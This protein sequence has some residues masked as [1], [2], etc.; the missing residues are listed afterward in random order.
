MELFALIVLVADGCLA[1]PEL[2]G[3]LIALVGGTQREQKSVF[4]QMIKAYISLAISLIGGRISL[5]LPPAN[6]FPV[7]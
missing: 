3:L 5:V 2:G 7:C 6:L 4:V 1:R